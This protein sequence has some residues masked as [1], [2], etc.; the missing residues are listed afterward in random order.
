MVEHTSHT[1]EILRNMWIMLI[2]A[3]IIISCNTFD[4]LVGNT[5]A[6]IFVIMIYF[7]MGFFIYILYNPF[8]RIKRV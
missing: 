1:I 7:F 5:P 2:G 3:F 6:F 8:K 4:Y